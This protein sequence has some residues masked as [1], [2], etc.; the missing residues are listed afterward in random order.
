[1]Y[2]NCKD[3]RVVLFLFCIYHSWRIKIFKNRYSN[4]SQALSNTS[5]TLTV[6][7]AVSLTDYVILPVCDYYYLFIDACTSFLVG[8]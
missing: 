4:Q 5:F 2:G 6:N 8:L 7:Y 1:M 3:N